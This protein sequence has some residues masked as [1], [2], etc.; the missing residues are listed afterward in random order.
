MGKV[1]GIILAA[2]KGER[3]GSPLNKV[4]LPLGDDPVIVHSLRVFENSG[5]VNT[6]VIAAAE[7]EVSYCRTLLSTYSLPKLVGIVPGGSIRQESVAAGLKALPEDCDLVVVHDGA[8]P[9]LTQEVLE[10]ALQRAQLSEAVVV[11]V[12]AKDTIKVVDGER[13]KATP[14]RSSLWL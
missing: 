11:A 1:G 5:M 3:M 14:E 4:Y 6:Y 8:R 10:G 7:S 13:I 12:P 9:L 2:G